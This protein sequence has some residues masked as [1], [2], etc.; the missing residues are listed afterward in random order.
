[1]PGAVKAIKVLKS[2]VDLMVISNTPLDTLNREWA[3]N[4]I[5]SDIEYIGGQETG[6]KTEMLTAAT[7]NKY[8][9]NNI[10]IIGDS[11][12]DLKAA[13]NIN[14]HFFPIIPLNENDSW[15]FFLQKGYQFFLNGNF[16]RKF[17]ISQINKFES[18]LAK[19][20]S[21]IV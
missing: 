6:N 14:A 19:K 16:S 10:L 11:P 7:K 12:G 15:E 1:M 4:K 2:K 3:E 8:E 9:N 17:Q 21:W 20:P 5:H 18:I 13:K